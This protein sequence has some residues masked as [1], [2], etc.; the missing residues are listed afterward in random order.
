MRLRIF[1]TV[2]WASLT[3]G[4]VIRSA[5][6]CRPLVAFFEGGGLLDDDLKPSVGLD[7]ILG[8]SLAVLVHHSEL[9]LRH[10]VSLQRGHLIPLGGFAVV[11]GYALA[12]AF[13]HPKVAS[14]VHLAELVSSVHVS[15]FGCLPEPLSSLAVVSEDHGGLQGKG[16]LGADVSLFGLLAELAERIDFLRLGESRLMPP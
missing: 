3:C 14:A 11:L 16:N 2:L 5:S 6:Q 9:V 8:H 4:W 7:E 12:F 13:L 15:P 10:D 1:S